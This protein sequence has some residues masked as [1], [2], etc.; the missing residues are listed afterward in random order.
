MFT[1]VIL[2]A[3]VILAVTAN[4]QWQ[5]DGP[6]ESHKEYEPESEYESQYGSKNEYHPKNGYKPKKVY[7]LGVDVTNDCVYRADN[8]YAIDDKPRSG[9]VAC[10]NKSAICM[11]CPYGL[12]F[13][14]K[15]GYKGLGQCLGKYDECPPR[16][17]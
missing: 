1:K 9:Y 14:S 3:S 5:S 11:P 15:A 13:C 7:C 16:S 10:V 4:E 6:T 12:V 2:I 17:Y 8:N